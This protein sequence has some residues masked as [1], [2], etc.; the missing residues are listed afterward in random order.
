[1][2]D[3]AAQQTEARAAWL[4]TVVAALMIA[5]LVAS[6]A[7]RDGFFLTEY[8]ATALPAMVFA[9]TAL[10]TL[11]VLTMARLLRNVA[12]AR[13]VPFLFGGSAMLFTG[14]AALALSQ[15]R[16]AAVVLFL[17]VFGLGALVVSGFWSVVNERFDPHTAK[18]LMG[19]IGG[20]ASLGGVVGGSV[21]F[22]GASYVDIPT[23]IAG[24]AL[25]NG[26]CVLGV[27]RIGQGTRNV[28]P[29]AENDEGARSAF[30]IVRETPYLQHIALL[31]ALGAFCQTAYDYVLKSTAAARFEAGAELVSFF[32]LFY[33]AVQIATFVVQNGTAGAVLRKLGIPTAVGSMPG[34]GALLGVVALLF[35][36]LASVV[37]MRAG[38]SVA[39]NSL[40]RSGYELLY[41]PILP[42]TKRP[43][44]FLID[45]CGDDVG[46]VFGAGFV[47]VVLQLLPGQADPALV[48]GGIAA[49]VGGLAVTRRLHRGYVWSL[50]QSLRAGRLDLG[51]DELSDATS[52]QAVQDTIAGLDPAALLGSAE[53]GGEGSTPG[54]D[55]ASLLERLRGRRERDA[56]RVA[57]APYRPPAD[58]AFEDDGLD[59]TT[60]AIVDLRSGDLGRARRVLSDPSPLPSE[61]VAHVVPLLGDDGLAP[62]AERSLQR[63]AAAHTGT[64]LDAVRQSRAGLAIRRR[65]CT[66]LAGLPTQRCTRGLLD[67]LGD[68]SFEIRLRAAAGLR[69]VQRR[70]AG[71]VIPHERLFAAAAGEAESC[72]RR[73]RSRVALDPRISPTPPLASA[74]GRRVVEGLSFAWTLLSCALEAEPLDLAIRALASPEGTHRG[75][76]LEY[77]ENVLPANLLVSLRPLLDDPALVAESLRNPDELHERLVEEEGAGVFDL[78]AL[79]RHVDAAR[80]R[81]PAVG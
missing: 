2:A 42:E 80:A 60:R 74:E 66:I 20:G 21:A 46:T 31:V 64:L 79:R 72:R 45:I 16:I 57:G 58:P 63:V 62:L 75:T 43:T 19:R 47:F 55:R 5:Q 35:P 81:R 4:T 52:Q 32:A 33:T 38:H 3:V 12:P 7:L 39:E 24:L 1:M 26:I 59:P 34:A 14:E 61:L 18:R 22:G 11:V 65:I 69:Q 71:L 27:V 53:A 29:S 54:I 44:K 30:R 73:W 50:A 68:D 36:G 10:S 76:G 77:L 9:A 49:S 8:D 41:T 48:L 78:E 6:I 40:F 70:N 23:M 15:P 37:A 17:H 56:V 28:E 13:S 25:V 51:A 67:L